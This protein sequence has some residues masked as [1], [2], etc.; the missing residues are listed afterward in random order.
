MCYFKRGRDAFW[1]KKILEANG[2]NVEV[3]G[4]EPN[5]GLEPFERYP[6][7]YPFQKEGVEFLKVQQAGILGFDMGLGKTPTALEFGRQM[8]Y[9]SIMVVAPSALCSQWNSELKKHFGYE[10]AV[11]ITGKITKSKRMDLYDSP[12]IIASYDILKYDKIFPHVEY[13]ILDEAQ[14]IKNWK[15]QRARAISLIVSPH[16]V[17]LTGTP[18]EN[19][20][21]D[22]YYI[23]DQI[24]PAFFG[25][26]SQFQENYI[27]RD[28]WGGIIGYNNLE[29]VYSMMQ[30][31]MFRKLKHEVEVE[32]P[33][34]ILVQRTVSWRRD[35]KDIYQRI[36]DQGKSI[37]TLAELKACA[38]NPAVKGN[39][40][41][42][43]SKET[44]LYELLEDELQGR[45]VIV[46]TQYK[47]NIPR[48]IRMGDELGIKH[49]HLMGGMTKQMDDIREKFDSFD[50]GVL[51]M[52][53]I[54]MYGLNLQSADVV[55]NF[56]LPWNPAHLKQ[57]YGRIDRIGSE[58]KS[59]LFVNLVSEDTIDDHILKLL[60]H[61]DFLFGATI[62]G[63]Q[64]HILESEFK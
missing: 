49:L 43:S 53:D 50:T 37:G 17:G 21:D 16:T 51:F 60:D 39:V 20:I 24:I 25:S 54:G 6:T 14:K 19:R 23:T 34:S 36:K 59:I 28:H 58:H 64:K 5:T 48:M 27:I 57:R 38:S 13:L 44:T 63:I 41:K 18:V 15:T 30:S 40:G 29:E 1:V 42:W 45:K 26:F 52:T 55:V 4:Y 8:G 47:K 3:E 61:K 33:E 56:D 22:L 62:D 31:I 46:F 11:V 7:L 12:F 35:E 32:L 9:E 2:M 10:D